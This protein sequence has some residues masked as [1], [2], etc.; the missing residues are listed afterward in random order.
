MARYPENK[1]N[2]WE[3]PVI[4]VGSSPNI[5]S[6]VKLWP[7][8]PQSLAAPEK[9]PRGGGRVVVVSEYPLESG[10]GRQIPEVS[11][12]SYGTSLTLVIKVLCVSAFHL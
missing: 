10:G 6:W 2:P 11:V 5:C 3:P 8:F 9:P 12:I 7:L 4:E 1:E